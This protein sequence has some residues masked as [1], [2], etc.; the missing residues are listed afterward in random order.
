MEI[1]LVVINVGNSRR[2]E[3]MPVSCTTRILV[4][5]SSNFGAKPDSS[6]KPQF[7]VGVT[8]TR[9]APG[10]TAHVRLHDS[11]TVHGGSASEHVAEGG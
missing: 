11:R 10:H 2:H 5:E 4:A 1:N 6:L 7:F 3:A 9:R 8:P